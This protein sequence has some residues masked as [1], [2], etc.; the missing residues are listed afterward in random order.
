M[1]DPFEDLARYYDRLMSHVDYARWFQTV[2][3]LGELLPGNFR[4]LD[5]ACGTSTLL[6]MLRDAGWNSMG[7]DISMAMLAR[8]R[9]KRP[10]TAL[11]RADIR[12]LP[13]HGSIDY[14]TC[15]F[16]SVN[17]L[18]EE[19]AVRS[20][21]GA[22]SAALRDGGLL[23]FDVVTRNMVVKH[24]ENQEWEEDH[25]KFNSFWSSTF[26]R[27]RN[28][29]ETKIRIN[30]GRSSMLSER[31]YPRKFI[32]DALKEARFTLLACYDATTW[33]R[34]RRRTTR[35]DF[36]AVKGRPRGMRAQFA[37]AAER[38]RLLLR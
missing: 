23:Y 35:L 1:P 24:F 27:A 5:A 2:T 11:A 20:A 32:E 15:L 30:S 3:G 25:G 6:H 9:K 28:V 33:K 36:V 18:L 31:I 22:F 8:G 14:I 26:D 38:Q 19:S 21:L 34:P 4:H 13:F 7:V 29:S 17:F 10:D 37:R 16:D 12:A